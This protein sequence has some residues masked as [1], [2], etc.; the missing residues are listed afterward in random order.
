LNLHSP[1][2]PLDGGAVAQVRAAAAYAGGHRQGILAAAAR[3]VVA[4]VAM[5]LC[6][7]AAPLAAQV[8]STG[9]AQATT[10]RVLS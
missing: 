4:A 5:I 7:A 8:A 1:S 2:A 6:L 3:I 9:T 10:P